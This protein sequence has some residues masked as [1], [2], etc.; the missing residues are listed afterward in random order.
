MTRLAV[1]VFA[2]SALA[3]QPRPDP[4]AEAR[5]LLA[6]GSIDESISL[7]RQAVA[8][9][10]KSADAHLLLGT[11]L[12]LVPKRT[13]AIA[14]IEKAIELRPASAAAHHT[15]G[16][17]YG[18]FAEPEPARS[19]FQKAIG[20]DPNFAAAHV[21]L[22]LIL[23]QLKESSSALSHLDQAIRIQPNAYAQLV[24]GRILMELDRPAEAAAAFER[25]VK[26]EPGN[27]AAFLDLGLAQRKLLRNGNALA[28]L[29]RAV[30][31]AP[32]NALARAELGK[33][34][35][36]EE[37]PQKAV[38][39]LTI[40][41]RL[42]PDDRTTLYGLSRALRATGQAAEAEAVE[43]RFKALLEASADRSA[44]Q[45]EATALNNAGVEL[46]KSGKYEAAL[47]KYG[48]ALELDP[49]NSGFRRNLALCLCRLGR[50]KEGIAE[51]RE[52]LRQNPDDEEA[53]RALYLALDQPGAR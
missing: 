12:S 15:L 20:L 6:A 29:R 5:R 19:A 38:E 17:A 46:E 14:E 21:S 24:K 43:K 11:A 33:L 39:H 26:T 35:L 52:V 47:A 50:W 49:L 8:R 41:N 2:A 48:A 53:T 45:F 36:G 32:N 1:F 3:Q 51:L 23:V 4:L 40:A 7:L 13:E 9:Q 27:A 44:T 31:L 30:E 10:P 25:A 18:R 37:Q 34:Y 42:R 22:A 16:L 28:S